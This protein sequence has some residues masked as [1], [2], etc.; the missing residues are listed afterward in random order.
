[1]KKKQLKNDPKASLIC[2]D[3]RGHGETLTEDD[4]DLSLDRLSRDLSDLVNVI[5]PNGHSD[6]VLVGHRFVFF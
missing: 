6:L 4:S 5:I 3:A 1:M 2:Y